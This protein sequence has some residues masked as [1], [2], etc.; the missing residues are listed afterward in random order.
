MPPS[1]MTV[2]EWADSK[3]ILLPRTSA[4][5]GVWRTS[6][7][8]YLKAVMDVFSIPEIE[9]ICFCKSVQVGGTEALYNMMGYAIEEEPAPMLMVLPTVEIAQYVS[10]NRFQ[11]MVDAIPSLAERKTT[12]DDE[13]NLL[14]MNFTGMVLSLGGA[15]SAPSLGTRPVRYLFLDEVD[16]FPAY[17]GRE[18]EPIGLAVARTTT[19][20]NRKIVKLSTPTVTGGNIWQAWLKATLRFKYYVPCPHCGAYQVLTFW[21]EELADYHLRWHE[22]GEKYE[23]DEVYENTWYECQH[24]HKKIYD[25]HKNAMVENGEWRDQYDHPFSMDIRAKSVAFHINALYSPWVKWGE[26]AAAFLKAKDSPEEYMNFVNL[27]LGEPVREQLAERIPDSATH[28]IEKYEP[29]IVPAEAVAI[30]VT[31]DVQKYYLQYVVRAWSQDLES[32]L[33]REGQVEG[34]I[35]LA[36]VV[37]NSSYPI[38]GSTK[39]MGAKLALIDAGYRTDEVYDFVRMYRHVCKATKGSSHPMRTP[40]VASKIDMYPD[41]RRM[42]DGLTLWIF[43]TDY[44]KDAFARRVGLT[45]GNETSLAKWHVYSGISTSYL[46]QLTAEEKITVRNRRTGATHEVWQ[47]KQGRKRNEAFD[48]EVMNLMGADMLGL[49]YFYGAKI[50]AMQQGKDAVA[51]KPKPKNT[52]ARS[53]WMRR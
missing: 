3:R 46:N 8:M 12:N 5:A 13:Y 10:R 33:I 17:A 26:M 40:Y 43:D 2:S 31:V 39:R 42:T 25:H 28:L 23:L 44:W 35:E 38:A 11:P 52:V 36:D 22:E 34:F 19:F 41:G 6:R 4:E 14:E 24:C 37:I 51:Q 29:G 16:K 45:E 47:L 7:A 48:L 15:N 21:G 49:K 20:W 1:G 9:E 18:G 50:V 30:I 53:N 32:W 27:Y